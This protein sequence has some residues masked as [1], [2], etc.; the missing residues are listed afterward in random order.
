MSEKMIILSIMDDESIP[1]ESALNTS[2]GATISLTL[3]QRL[4]HMQ[5][6]EPQTGYMHT[7]NEQQERLQTGR[8]G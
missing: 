2:S 3:M 6:A 7:R 5:V 1:S 4:A 8:A